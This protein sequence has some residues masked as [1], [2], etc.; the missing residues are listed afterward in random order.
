M[1]VLLR[2][3]SWKIDPDTNK[4]FK[5]WGGNLEYRRGSRKKGI[6]KGWGLVWL[7]NKDVIELI[8]LH[9]H[10]GGVQII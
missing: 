5:V 3:G 2:H 9:S 1:I 4:T 10:E 8:E 6:T 7:L